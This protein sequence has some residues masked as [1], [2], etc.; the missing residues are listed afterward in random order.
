MSQPCPE[1]AERKLGV[2]QAD[3]VGLCSSWASH[4]WDGTELED[5]EAIRWI[6]IRFAALLVDMKPSERIYSDGFMRAAT[7]DYWGL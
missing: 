6:S 1:G 3:L 5:C 7:K 4:N 2:S